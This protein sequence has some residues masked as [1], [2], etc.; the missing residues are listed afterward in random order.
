MMEQ[1]E[2][3]LSG[4]ILLDWAG[5]ESSSADHQELYL[6]LIFMNLFK[7]IL[8]VNV[9]VLKFFMITKYYSSLKH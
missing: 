5:L 8:S 6:S 4:R 2:R 7:T 9:E 3:K 1:Q